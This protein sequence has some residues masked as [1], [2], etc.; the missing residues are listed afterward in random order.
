MLVVLQIQGRFRFL[1]KLNLTLRNVSSLN[2]DAVGIVLFPVFWYSSISSHFSPD[3]S[4]LDILP[5]YRGDDDDNV[6]AT[7]LIIVVIPNRL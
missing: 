2:R 3:V 7:D 1:S 5:R 6:T 4:T